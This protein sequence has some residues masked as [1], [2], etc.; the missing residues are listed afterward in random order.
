MDH[1]SEEVELRMAWS[2]VAGRGTGGPKRADEVFDDLI[3]RHRAASRRYHGV[4]HVL[5][6]VRH[7]HELATTAGD[8][9]L[10]V[11]LAAAFFHDAVYEPSSADN[12]ERSAVLAERQ[13]ASMGW[14]APG[15]AHVGR[16]IR[17]TASHTEAAAVPPPDDSCA[18]LLDADLAVLG[19]EP[20]SYQAYVA[21]VRAEYG[22]LDDAAWRAG[23]IAVLHALAERRDLYVTPSA[24]ERWDAAARANLAAELAAL[25][26]P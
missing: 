19:A 15:V 14:A 26:A 7:V 23:R 6:V 10:P 22:H 9:D 11:V 4:R 8:V 20:A 5:W 12:E 1:V 17:A 16:C 25:G 24:R 13:L 18:V 3:G 2:A 21:G